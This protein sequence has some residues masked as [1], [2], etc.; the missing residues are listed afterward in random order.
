MKAGVED[1]GVTFNPSRRRIS[2]LKVWFS[3]VQRVNLSLVRMRER[4]TLNKYQ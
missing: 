1:W 4:E 3:I 2:D